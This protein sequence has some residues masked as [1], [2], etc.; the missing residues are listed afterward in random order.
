MAW[1]AALFSLTTW[2]IR[3]SVRVSAWITVTPRVPN[4]AAMF[5]AVRSMAVLVQSERGASAPPAVSS[6]S[7]MSGVAST[8]VLAVPLQA[9]GALS[10][11]RGL[12]A[13][14]A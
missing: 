13:S 3:A 11:R 8:M 2:L 5:L 10:A 12:A 4:V 9:M 14:Q 1:P 7:S 6:L